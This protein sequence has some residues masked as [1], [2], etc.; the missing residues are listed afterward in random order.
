MRAYIF[1]DKDGVSN[2]PQ[3][4]LD[5][6]DPAY[7]GQVCIRSSKNTYNQTLLASIV[8]HHG[9][10]KAR[11]WAEGVVANMARDPQGGDTDQMRGI[12][13][14]ECGI[15]VANSYYFARSIRK[16]VKGISDNRDQIGWLFPSQN[17]EGAHM[18]LS[19][20]GVAVHAPNKENAIKFLEYLSSDSAQ[21]YFSAGND[22]YPAVSG[23]GLAPSIAALGHFKPDD[24]NLSEVAK[25]LP[26]AQKIF[27]D[28]GWK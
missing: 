9:A 14:G 25:N 23:V 19:G 17:E 18:N 11:E 22:E 13:S 27:N 2:P 24:V 1:F 15:A 20:G 21:A 7:K 26:E 10:E 12:V 16:D 3:T 5:L 28:V 8:T 4:Y 6:A